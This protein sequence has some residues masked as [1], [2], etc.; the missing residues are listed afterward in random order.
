MITVNFYTPTNMQATTTWY[1]N[2]T[3]KTASSIT[4]TDGVNT[5]IYSGNFTY[6]SNSVQGTV[7]GYQQ[8]AGTNLVVSIAGASF[9]AT[10]VY[11]LVQANLIQNVYALAANQSVT[12]NGS[13]GSDALFGYGSYNVF[14]GNGGNDTITGFSAASAFNVTNYQ[15][16]RSAYRI[17]A[18][19]GVLTVADSVSGRDGSDTLVNVQYVNFSDQAIT[20]ARSN[21]STQFAALLYQGALG[22]TPDPQGLAYWINLTENLSPQAKA[23]GLYGLSDASANYNGNLSIAGGFTNSAEFIGKYGALTNAQFVTQLYANILDRA[24]DPG[25]YNDWTSQLANGTS[26]EHILVGF[27]ESREALANATLGYTGV[28]GPHAAWLMIS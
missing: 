6:W 18:N 10:S 19:A 20:V 15:G 5:G 28:H 1:G 27:A 16:A 23:L 25:G 9:N 11:N 3:G 17:T 7:M 26:R 21:T 8:Y 24:A 14:A 12:I 4:V 2:V 13:S 22:R